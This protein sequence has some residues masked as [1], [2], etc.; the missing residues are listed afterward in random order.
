MDIVTF[1]FI[2]ISIIKLRILWNTT[3]MTQHW[4][5]SR[6]EVLFL[7]TKLVHC[8]YC[9]SVV[10]LIQHSFQ[11][12]TKLRYIIIKESVH[13]IISRFF[14]IEGALNFFFIGTCHWFFPLSGF[15]GEIMDCF[16]HVCFF[17][18]LLCG[19]RNSFFLLT[20]WYILN[21]SLLLF[22]WICPFYFQIFTILF[23]T[24]RR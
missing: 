19:H 24:V 13:S 12:F 4:N 5:I 3:T 1:Y 21:K 2:F 17:K 14:Q 20:Q 11:I 18:V 23:L 8:L 22:P 10:S 6:L 9:C 16:L 7:T 15:S